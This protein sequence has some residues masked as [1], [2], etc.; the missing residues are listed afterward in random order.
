M[1]RRAKRREKEYQQKHWWK[2]GQAVPT[3]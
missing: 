1:L 3:P 2:P